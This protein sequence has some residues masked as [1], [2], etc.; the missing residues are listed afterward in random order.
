MGKT[1]VEEFVAKLGFEIDGAALTN[2]EKKSQTLKKTLTGIGRAASI[3]AAAITGVVAVSNRG[4]AKTD[5]LAKSV[6]ITTENLIALSNA[7]KPLGFE[8]DNVV[9]LVEEMNNKFGESTGLGEQ[10]TAVR[11]SVQILGLEFEN[12]KN[13]APEEQFY[14]ILD[15]ALQLEDTQQA[16]S[17]VDMLTGGEGNKILGFLREEGKSIR[18]IIADQKRLNLLTEDGIAGAKKFDS[19]FLKLTTVGKSLVDQFSG[20][21]GEVLGPLIDD[22][23]EWIIANEDLIQSELIVWAEELGGFLLWIFESLRD[24]VVV[25]GGLIEKIGGLKVAFRLF[26]VVVSAI[27]VVQFAQWIY[28]TVVAVKAM[29]VAIGG[30]AGALKILKL[31]SIGL[32]WFLIFGLIFLLIE[33]FIG[34]LQGKD[35]VIGDMSKEF[36]KLLD[37]AEEFWSEVFGVNTDQFRSAVLDIWESDLGEFLSAS[38][39]QWGDWFENLGQWF[40]SLW[41]GAVDATEQGITAVVNFVMEM[42]NGMVEEMGLLIT[43][44]VDFWTEIGNGIIGFFTGIGDSIKNIVATAFEFVRNNIGKLMDLLPDKVKDFLGVKT[45]GGKPTGKPKTGGLGKV[46]SGL[47]AGF[48]GAGRNLVAGFQGP[49]PVAAASGPTININVPTNLAVTQ[50]GEMSPERLTRE[51]SKAIGTEVSRAVRNNSEGV[52]Y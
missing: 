15:A 29:S 32:K 28:A 5:A 12:L 52:S 20:K 35:S 36:E 26:L 51:V 2:F 14:S 24:I 38:G 42:Y 49:T 7:V 33:D 22:L 3:A 8:V 46:A 40:V 19:A 34:F 39:E 10:M 4:T 44:T 9:D 30:L 47:G 21:L 37:D 31:A 13:L 18:Q 23:V 1:Y 48:A 16:V 43:S 50:K 6:G 41:E 11:E 17:A 25:A 45:T 27:V